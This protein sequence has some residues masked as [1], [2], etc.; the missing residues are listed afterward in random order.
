MRE[1]FEIAAA[2]NPIEAARRNTRPALRRRFYAQASVVPSADG[3]GLTLDGKPVRT[4]AGRLLTLPSAAL[5]EAIA[6]EWEAQRDFIDPA[7]M[8]LTRL[9]NSIIDGVGNQIEA[10]ADDVANYLGTDLVCYRAG[11]PAGLVARQS[12]HWDPLV[13]FARDGLNARFVLG[14]GIMP[15]AQP[16]EAL[17]AARAAI[18]AD[19]WRLG[20]VHAVTT[21]SGSALIALA[22][23]RGRIAAEE[24]WKAA[25]VDEDWNA[26][27]WG[28]DDEAE[29][30]R[31]NR[32]AEFDAAAKVLRLL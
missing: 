32:R 3:H 23:A 9:A 2:E 8:P 26:D 30:R 28:R 24:A 7:L 14:V 18:P 1:L 4:P 10:V 13:A 31:T 17:A 5:A 22:L 12:Q 11:H 15:V 27:Q 29:Q 19:P 16:A 20:A 21:I 6:D 25:Q